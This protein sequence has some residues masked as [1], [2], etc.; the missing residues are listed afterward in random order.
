VLSTALAELIP[1][2][3]PKP[4]V[5]AESA[6]WLIRISIVVPTAVLKSKS[7]QREVRL[8]VISI[9]SSCGPWVGARIIGDGEG[10]PIARLAEAKVRTKLRANRIS[11][12]NP[13]S[14][15]I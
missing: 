5:A 11:P 8:R 14:V 15:V 3:A 1:Q 13:N 6:P 2:L 10:L 7:I 9:L 12:L 4:I